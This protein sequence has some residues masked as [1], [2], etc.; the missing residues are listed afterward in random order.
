MTGHIHTG[1]LRPGDTAE[2]TDTQYSS[3]YLGQLGS[4]THDFVDFHHLDSMWRVSLPIS[5]A[6]EEPAP[7]GDVPPARRGFS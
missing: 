2:Q 7:P 6:T 1:W 4:G 5:C 3:S